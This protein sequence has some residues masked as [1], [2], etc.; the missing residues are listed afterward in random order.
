M[1]QLYPIFKD[2]PDY[3]DYTDNVLTLKTWLG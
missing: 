3:N 1:N 2:V